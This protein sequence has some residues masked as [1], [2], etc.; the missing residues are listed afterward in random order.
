MDTSTW[1][2]RTVPALILL[3]RGWHCPLTKATPLS[4]AVL[5]FLQVPLER[6]VKGLW[7]E[8]Q[9]SLALSRLTPPVCANNHQC[10]C[11][12]REKHREAPQTSWPW[13]LCSPLIKALPLHGIYRG[14][15]HTPSTQLPR[16]VVSKVRQSCK[17]DLT[18]SACSSGPFY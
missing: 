3:Q 12:C 6:S 8:T 13:T 2:N 16:L 11:G 7:G 14:V 9:L 5:Y 1:P 4:P 15:L 18:A 10:H 17:Q